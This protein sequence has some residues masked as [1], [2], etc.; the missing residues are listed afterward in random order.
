M[1]ILIIFVSLYKDK[2]FDMIIEYKGDTNIKG[3]INELVDYLESSQKELWVYMGMKV[4]LDPTVDFTNQNLLVRWIDIEEGFN[5]KIIV[6]SLKEF[7][8]HFK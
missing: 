8:T 6:H 2:H 1:C 7:Q 3:E 5:D 4:E